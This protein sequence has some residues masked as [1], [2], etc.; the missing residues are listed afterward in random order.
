[1]KT[2]L[3][4]RRDQDEIKL[5][6]QQSINYLISIF[7]C[8]I[9]G[10][11]I[12]LSLVRFI[13]K[14]KPEEI[15]N[16]L[17]TDYLLQFDAIVNTVMNYNQFILIIIALLLSVVLMLAPYFFFFH[18]IKLLIKILRKI[19]P[20][21]KVDQRLLY[22]T[23]MNYDGIFITKEEEL[24]P[25]YLWS[26]ICESSM[27]SD[28]KLMQDLTLKLK[29]GKTRTINSIINFNEVNQYI[30]HSLIKSAPP[31]KQN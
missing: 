7:S 31:N 25:L 12:N 18:A 6:V 30:Q 29:N 17:L 11:F 9:I 13:K 2:R 23:H 15:T 20:E 28:K 4:I 24:I 27:S 19:K 5:E 1:M 21:W 16:H 22:E 8:I 3:D 10:C 14:S 26:E